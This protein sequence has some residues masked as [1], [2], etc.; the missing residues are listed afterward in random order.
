MDWLTLVFVLLSTFVNNSGEDGIFNN[1]YAPVIFSGTNRF[2]GN[3]GTPLKVSTL[4]NH[5]LSQMV[6]F[7][8]SQGL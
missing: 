5:T 2:I 4:F 7:I 6:T 3:R 8:L 1:G